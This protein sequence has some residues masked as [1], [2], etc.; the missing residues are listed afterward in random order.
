MAADG[1]IATGLTNTGVG[2]FILAIAGALLITLLFRASATHVARLITARLGRSRIR[3]ILNARRAR[4]RK[5][6]SA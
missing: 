3:K 6:L 1:T 5:K 2:M 4:G